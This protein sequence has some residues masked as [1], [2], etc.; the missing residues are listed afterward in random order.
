MFVA[1]SGARD[2]DSAHR[3]YSRIRRI[4]FPVLYRAGRAQLL[5]ESA[6]RRSHRVST[7]SQ[8]RRG[9]RLPEHEQIALVAKSIELD[10]LRGREEPM[11]VPA[12]QCVM[13]GV[14]CLVRCVIQAGASACSRAVQGRARRAHMP[15]TR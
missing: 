14:L 11:G 2:N 10:A 5:G 1:S 12:E 7:R 15:G 3:S 13:M 4:R 8:E 6:L 9:V